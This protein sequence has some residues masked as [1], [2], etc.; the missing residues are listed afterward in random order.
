MVIRLLRNT[1]VRMPAG[2]IL[3]VSDEE[4]ARL[5]ALGNAKK[6][7]KPKKETKKGSK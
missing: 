5:I 1:V 7:K 2:I 3:E 4:G 6:E